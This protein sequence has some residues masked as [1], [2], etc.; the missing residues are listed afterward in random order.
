MS[1]PVSNQAATQIAGPSAAG[2][3]AA[4]LSSEKGRTYDAYLC[5]GLAGIIAMVVMLLLAM[6]APIQGA[7]LAPGTIVV[8]GKSKV[9]QHLD[10]GIVGEILVQ[11]GDRVTEG[12]IMMRLDPTS[13]SA[14]RDLLVNRLLEAKALQ[15]RLVAERD[16]ENRIDWREA[17][18][19]EERA[20]GAKKLIKDQTELFQTRRR[21]MQGQTDQLRSRAAQQRDQISGFE[22][23][24]V[25]KQ[26]Q[27][28]LTE[29]Q[30]EG[31]QTLVDKDIIK[32]IY[33]S[34]LQLE[35]EQASL[36]GE[37]AGSQSEIARMR[38]AIGETEIEILQTRRNF[39]ESVLTELRST[40]SQISDLS[41]QLISAV[42][43]TGRIDIKA[44]VT[45]IVHNL[46]IT[47]VGG[48]VSPVN[49]IME[50]IP[51]DTALIVEARVEPANIDQVY[52]GQKTDV[53][54]SAFNARTTPEL[55]G[56]VISVG[57]ATN[58]DQVTG[59]PYYTIKVEVGPDQL[60]RLNGQTLIPGMPA[61]AFMQTE[62]RSVWNYLI[63]PAS[64]QFSRAL[65][66]E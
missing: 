29:K 53:R 64:D 8:Q 7:V 16:N 18:S 65:R 6:F 32:D 35:R 1:N 58:I 17:F 40:E 33:S 11:D 48:V 63:K 12:D 60:K 46:A 13:L 10:G 36:R 49:P 23:I 38:N 59:L 2:R 9:V 24:I 4:G 56:T 3:A 34:I 62:Q 44:P 61:E 51:S 14:N 55:I 26:Q 54:M 45:G 30:L 28:A 39:Q 31:Q 27:L 52:V 25:A 42:D 20:G 37:I 22:S 57:A 41:E 43:Q 21:A 15:A 47:T 50:I 66:E 5:I 19:E